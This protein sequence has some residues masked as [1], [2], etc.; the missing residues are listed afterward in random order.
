MATFLKQ[1]KLK[2][3]ND[4]NI[5]QLKLFSKAAWTFVSAI[6]EAGWNQINTVDN[7]T[8]QSKVKFQF[9]RNQSPL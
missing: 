9:I 2:G 5:S 6:Y 1:K 8:F 3:C 7:I 4:K